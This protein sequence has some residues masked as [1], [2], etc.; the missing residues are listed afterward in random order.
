LIKFYGTFW[1]PDT[2][3]W[4]KRGRGNKG[5]LTGKVKPNRMHIDFWE[6][7]GIYV[8]HD[9]FKAIYVGQTM[10]PLG[11]RLRD[12]LSDRLAGRWDMFSWFSISAIRKTGRD[13]SQPGQRQV[14]PET[15]V[16]T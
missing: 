13:V 4:G 16:D 1:N 2:V 10:D 3:D 6:A 11:G 5:K 12:H 15:V 14:R 9:N 7:R 8:L